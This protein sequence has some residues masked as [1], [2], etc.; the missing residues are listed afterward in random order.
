MV[1][2]ILLRWLIVGSYG[3]MLLGLA[4]CVDEPRLIGWIS[5]A[6][7]VAMF[8]GASAGAVRNGGPE[9]LKDIWFPKGIWHEDDDDDDYYFP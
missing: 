1:N 3:V 4:L 2:R 8:V 7:G 5:L 9:L 6:V